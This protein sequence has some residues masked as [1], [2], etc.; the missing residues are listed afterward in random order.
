[1]NE[2]IRKLFSNLGSSYA[3]QLGFRDSWVF[4]GAKDLKNKSPFEQVGSWVLPCPSES[5]M[6]RD[7]HGVGGR[8]FPWAIFLVRVSTQSQQGGSHLCNLPQFGIIQL[9]KP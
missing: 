8:S 2:E 1:M 6:D 9:A 4:L 7:L 5:W 3:K